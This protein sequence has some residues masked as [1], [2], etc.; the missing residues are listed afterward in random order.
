MRVLL[1][2]DVLL[3]VAL[4]RE[5]HVSASAEVLR[6]AE[7]EGEA[8]VAWHSLTNCANLLKGSGREFL[9]QLLQ[10]V[11]VATVGTEDA[12]RALSLPM[13][14]VEDAFQVSAALAWGADFI[15][16]RNLEDYRYSPVAALPPSAFLNKLA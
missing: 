16:T 9:Q 6:W 5:P 15:I 10:I 1:D 11:T 3:D 12:R 4:A 14:D 8:A 2:T 7:R 13:K